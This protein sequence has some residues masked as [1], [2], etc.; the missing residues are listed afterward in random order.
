M[1]KQAANPI[2]GFAHSKSE[3]LL[4][5]KWSSQYAQALKGP[6]NGTAMTKS[7]PKR[8]NQK[9]QK[10]VFGQ[11]SVK[12][13]TSGT[14]FNGDRAQTQLAK[15]RKTTRPAGVRQGARLLPQLLENLQSLWWVKGKSQRYSIAVPVQSYSI[16]ALL[17]GPLGSCDATF[18]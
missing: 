15:R 18:I 5:L 12:S 2:G 11:V 14:E 1:G 8:G 3:P 4:L 6:R 10:V 7:E 13:W 9:G 16:A 17:K